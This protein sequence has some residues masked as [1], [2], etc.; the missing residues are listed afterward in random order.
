[1]R[2]TELIVKVNLSKKAKITSR[3]STKK[4]QN[5]NASRKCHK[6]LKITENIMQIHKKFETVDFSDKKLES[7]QIDN[8]EVD[9]GDND[10]NRL[11]DFIN[12]VS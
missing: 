2:P 9:A 7:S 8:C 11:L 4:K 1:M 10:N 3:C 12:H 5:E 6:S